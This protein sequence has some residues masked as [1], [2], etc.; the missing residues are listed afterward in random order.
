M[1]I[2]INF[3]DGRTTTSETEGKPMAVT[4]TKDESK[5]KG[6]IADRD[7]YLNA[8]KSKVVEEGDPAM[9]FVFVGKG[10][11]VSNEDVEK[12]G[13]TFGSS[14]TEKAK[15]T[16]APAASVAPESASVEPQETG[17]KGKVS[18]D[19]PDDF[20]G[21]ESLVEAGYETLTSVK[22]ASDEDL[23]EVTGIGKATLDKIRGYEEA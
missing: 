21:F 23:L 4:V 2:T 7:L 14:E 13:L 12:Y 15:E 18:D 17:A 11:T 6:Q 1:G 10:G 8:D 16:S 9:A 20:P 3:A 5:P 19:L 22:D